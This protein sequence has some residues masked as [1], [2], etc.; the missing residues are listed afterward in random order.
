MKEYKINIRLEKENDF[1]E[2]ENLTREA[3]WN[4]YRPG[5]LEHLVVHNLRQ[6]DCY[7]KDL[8]YV[9]ETDGK[10][11]ANIVYAVSNVTDDSGVNREVLIF[12]PI[13]VLP[14]YQ[15][16]GYGEKLISFTV[17]KAK[18]L[19]YAAIIITGNPEYYKK[20]GFIP[21]S[22]YGIYYDGL[23]KSEPA[24]FFMIKVLDEEKSKNI[25]GVY[26]DPDCY[27]VNEK[28]LELFDKQFPVKAK[29]IRDGQLV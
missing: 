8:D 2:V 6:S 15:K 13:S 20:Y 23:P 29:E 26:K 11:I 3:F 21:C 4:V 28:E 1:F 16:K 10:I 18:D 25:K 27:N 14:E 19:G 12:G 5:C 24:P 7:V 17:K 9:L 22:D